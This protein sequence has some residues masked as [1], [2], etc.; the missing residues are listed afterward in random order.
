MSELKELIESIEELNH[1]I[2]DLARMRNEQFKLAKN[3]GFD[4]KV[5]KRT[6]AVRKNTELYETESE[7]VKIYMKEI[8]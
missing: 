8:V 3:K 7:L 5:I 4:V 2:K 6:I 1:Q